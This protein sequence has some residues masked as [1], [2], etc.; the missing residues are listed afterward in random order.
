MR[1]LGLN[2]ES[3]IV[4]PVGNIDNA[5]ML[6]GTGFLLQLCSQKS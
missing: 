2:L 5:I 4:S 6:R 3:Y 1:V